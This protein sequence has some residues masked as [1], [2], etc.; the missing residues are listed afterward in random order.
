VARKDADTRKQ[1]IVDAAIRLADKVGP[2]RLTTEAVAQDVGITQPAV[3]RHFPKKQSLWEAVAKHISG[4]M[5]KRW[6]RVLGDRNPA[7]ERL[8]A[9]I[10]AQ[11]T[12]IRGNPAIPAIL[13]SRELH[14]GNDALRN[15]FYTLMGKFHGVIAGLIRAGVEEG[16]FRQDLDTRDAAFLVLGLVQGL[17]VRWSFSGK[18]FDIV[19]E[20]RR[21]FELQMSAFV[22]GGGNDRTGGPL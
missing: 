19:E 10:A 4:R 6:A 3:F 2:D 22:D 20:G 18:S 8:H 14:S 17:A 12:F 21:L 5:Q 1:E 16:T 15:A 7:D 13:F 9:L 11:L